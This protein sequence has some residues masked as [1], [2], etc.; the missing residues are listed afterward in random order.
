MIVLFEVLLYIYVCLNGFLLCYPI[1][2]LDGLIIFQG[3]LV[4]LYS[5]NNGIREVLCNGLHLGIWYF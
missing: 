3:F 1:I 5:H 2:E 4:F